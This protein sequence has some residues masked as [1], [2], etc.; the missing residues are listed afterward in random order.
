MDNDG[1]GEGA[2]AIR[3]MRVE[4][5]SDLPGLSIFNIFKIFGMNYRHEK[6]ER[7]GAKECPEEHDLLD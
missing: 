5:K 4:A 1:R 7:A 3:N 2:S 6:R